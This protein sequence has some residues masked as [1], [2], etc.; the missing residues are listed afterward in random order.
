L[1]FRWSA[2][3]FVPC[4]P[5][6]WRVACSF[7]KIWSYFRSSSWMSWAFQR[8]CGDSICYCSNCISNILST[9]TT[10]LQMK[11]CV[12][13]KS[14]CHNVNNWNES[15]QSMTI[16]GGGVKSPSISA[17]LRISLS[18]GKRISVDSLILKLFPLLRSADVERWRLNRFYF[19]LFYFDYYLLFLFF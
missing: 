19:Y 9:T 13:L 14:L 1:T 11:R 16:N 8:F 15:L 10:S 17:R 3:S 5:E 2:S 6:R 18:D 12:N 7:S 4:A